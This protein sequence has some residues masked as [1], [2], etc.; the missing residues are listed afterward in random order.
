MQNKDEQNPM[1]RIAEALEGIAAMLEKMANPMIMVRGRIADV[2]T[3]L[4]F[5][6]TN[7]ISE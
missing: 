2:E 7:Y 5:G 6:E 3:T 4:K 1:V